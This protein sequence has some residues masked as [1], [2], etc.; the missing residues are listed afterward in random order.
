MILTFDEPTI[1]HRGNSCVVNGKWHV[2]A[3]DPSFTPVPVSAGSSELL[4]WMTQIGYNVVLV[5]VR[6]RSTPSWAM[7]ATCTWTT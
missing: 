6:L 5:L 7:S 3:P 1:A 2:L 4:T